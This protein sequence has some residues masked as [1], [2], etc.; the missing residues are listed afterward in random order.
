[1]GLKSKERDDKQNAFDNIPVSDICLI[2]EGTYPY[3]T[4]G[5]SSWIHSIITGIPDLTFSIL[6]ISSSKKDV[7]KFRYDLPDNVISMVDVSLHDLIIHEN[8]TPGKRNKHKAH[9]DIL[10]FHKEMDDQNFDRFNE[11]YK[12]FCSPDERSLNTSDIINSPELWDVILKIYNDKKL[13]NSFID[14]YWTWRFVHMPLFQALNFEIPKAKVYHAVSTGYAGLV[15]AIAKLRFDAPLLLTEH[16]IYTKERSI[17]IRRSDWIYVDLPLQ[18]RPQKS[19]GLFKEIWNKFFLALSRITYKYSDEII[20]LYKGNRQLQVEHGAE[21]NKCSIIPNAIDTQVFYPLRKKIERKSKK[22]IGFVGRVVPIKDVKTLI[23]AC[24]LVESEYKDVEFLIL[25]PID[26]D[27]EYFEEC[28]TLTDLLGLTHKLKFYGRVDVS[29]YYPRINVNVLTSISEGQP[30]TILEA[31]AVGVPSV[32][33]N[34]GACEDLLYGLTDEDKAL[35]KSGLITNMGSPSETANAILKIISNE[36][37]YK[38]M[39]ESGYKRVEKYYRKELLIER[40]KNL[41]RNYLHG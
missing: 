37:L 17:E 6:H 1:M 3:V 35:G 33:T 40:Y 25:G 5:V 9:E 26:E 2:N 34:V 4:G 22:S 30:L 39:V 23:K 24:K 38:Q 31:M 32:S 18:F 19:Q 13:D 15:G 20:T 28:K 7:G 41:Y 14:Y 21:F 36:E 12:H 11:I 10:K 8:E 29:Q 16:G 27:E